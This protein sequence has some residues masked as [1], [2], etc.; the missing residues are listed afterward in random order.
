MNELFLNNIK[1]IAEKNI[2]VF[3]KLDMGIFEIILNIIGIFIVVGILGF[4]FAGAL[5]LGKKG[6]EKIRDIVDD[7][8]KLDTRIKT[9]PMDSHRDILETY[10]EGGICILIINKMTRE[11]IDGLFKGK[12]KTNNSTFYYETGDKFIHIPKS[13]LKRMRVK[14]A[15]PVFCAKLQ[16][17]Y[18]GKNYYGNNDNLPLNQMEYGGHIWN[19]TA[20]YF[21]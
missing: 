20:Y 10:V 17:M 7:A 12:L 14:Q 19:I 18:K 15:D 5:N 3:N 8:G 1:R 2:G 21:S 4:G 16:M 9:Q 6:A 13:I 11:I